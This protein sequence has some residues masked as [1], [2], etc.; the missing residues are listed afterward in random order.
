MS[1]FLDQLFKSPVIFFIVAAVILIVFAIIGKIPWP[2]TVDLNI[3]QRASLAAFGVVLIVLSVIVASIA[4]APPSGGSVIQGSTLT[5]SPTVA[6]PTTSSLQSSPISDTLPT[7]V[8][9][10]SCLYDN[11]QT[12]QSK[13][14]P[15]TNFNV[16]EVC[17]LI[18]D[19]LRGQLNST[20]W[21]GGGVYAYPSGIYN[22]FIFDGEYTLVGTQ[23][24]Y[25]EFCKIVKAV[26]SR[27]GS[28][29]SHAGPLP[30]WGLSEE[31]LL[32][33]GGC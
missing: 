28:A 25:D 10:Q 22:G 17:V 26:A 21:T 31:G 1:I 24:A 11:Q 13:S 4:V 3:P 5:P 32:K 30:E 23:E 16:S 33:K 14:K 8:P 27:P 29:F 7:A 2:S 19:S 9:S 18:I 12:G 6:L 15:F 20:I